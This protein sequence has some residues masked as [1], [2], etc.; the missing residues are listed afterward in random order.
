MEKYYQE[1]HPVGEV[2]SDN[3]PAYR[4]RVLKGFLKEDVP[5]N[6]IDDFRELLQGD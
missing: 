2:M 4:V 1:V 3:Q 5:L 6:T